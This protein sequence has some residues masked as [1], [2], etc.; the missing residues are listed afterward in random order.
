MAR[1]VRTNGSAIPMEAGERNCKVEIQQLADGDPTGGSGA[2]V[3]RWTTLATVWMKRM[4]IDPIRADYGEK[5]LHNQVVA[6]P[7]QFW[8][9]GYRADMDPLDINVPKKRRLVYRSR[10]YNIVAA[11]VIGSR[12]GL[13][14]ITISLGGTP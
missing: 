9:M 5:Y 13:E 10:E 6:Q 4:A 12:E 3:E 7:Q 8:E 1:R 11:D 2:P 14:L